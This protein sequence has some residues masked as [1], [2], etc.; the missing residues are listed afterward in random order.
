MEVDSLGWHDRHDDQAYLAAA[1]KN[2]C[3]HPVCWDEEIQVLLLVRLLMVVVVVVGI[4][5]WHYWEGGRMDSWEEKSTWNCWEQEDSQRAGCLDNCCSWMAM[6]VDSHLKHA[7]EGSWVATEV[8][9]GSW[10]EIE[11]LVGSLKQVDI[12]QRC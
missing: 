5:S 3:L 7:G 4:Q 1:G 2:D 8:L 6:R 12:R 11:V 10:R 9:V